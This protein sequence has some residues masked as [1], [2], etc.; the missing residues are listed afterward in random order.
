MGIF[1]LVFQHNFKK[2]SF[3]LK[4]LFF[5]IPVPKHRFLLLF[6]RRI[7]R[8]F[9]L[10]FSKVKLVTS[11]SFLFKGKLSVTGNKRT[12]RFKKL[13]G[14]IKLPNNYLNHFTIIRTNTGVIGF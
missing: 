4:L 2:F 5:Q 10:V 7:F 6:F 1:E 9:Y 3:L 8:K 14:Y 12:R 13:F 11:V